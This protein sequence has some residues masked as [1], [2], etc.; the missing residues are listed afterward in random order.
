[1]R[2]LSLPETLYL[3]IIVTFDLPLLDA[4]AAFL[5]SKRPGKRLTPEQRALLVERGRRFRFFSK[6]D[7]A[8]EGL[9]RPDS[10]NGR[11]C[12]PFLVPAKSSQLDA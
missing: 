3:E 6:E 5:R 8:N 7:G 9:A 2:S 10:T 11:L 4:V 12:R 1:M